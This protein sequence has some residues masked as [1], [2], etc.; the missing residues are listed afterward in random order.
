[1]QPVNIQGYYLSDND[2]HPLRWRFP[3]REIPPG[4][5]LLVF[6]SGKN[7]FGDQLHTNF[8]ISASGEPLILSDPDG[9][10]LDYIPAVP[11]PRDVSY[12]RYPDGGSHF[13]FFDLPTPGSTNI[14]PFETAI[15]FSQ[16][17]GFYADTLALEMEVEGNFQIF[18]TLNG[19]L[20]TTSDSLYIGPLVLLPS[21]DIE[22][23]PIIYIPTNHESSDWWY[24]WRM[25]GEDLFRSHVVRAR[26][27]E[28]GDP[29]TEIKTA[30]YFIDSG[31]DER[32]DLPVISIVS[33]EDGLFD[34]EN[35]IF[36][37][38]QGFEDNPQQGGFW[39]GGNFHN[40]G[41]EWEREAG[42]FFFENGE[43]ALEQNLGIRIH[44]S[45]SRSLP[46]KSLR[47]YA[48]EG[49]GK[50]EIEY[51]FFP[52]EGIQR[53]KRLLLRNAGQDFLK[54][55]LADPLTHLIISD[56]DVERQLYRPAVLFINGAY[57]GI[58]NI[59]ERLD[60]YYFESHF[61][62][63]EEEL[64]LIS[65]SWGIRYEVNTGTAND[66]LEMMEYI[67]VN[68]LSD[69]LHFDFV[70]NQIDLENFISYYIGKMF[71]GTRDWPGNN[72]DFWRDRSSDGKWRWI[73]FDNDDAFEDIY[74]N[75]YDYL[76]ILSG[77][78]WPNPLWT[79][80]LFRSLMEN[81]GFRQQFAETAVHQLKTTYHP[82]RTMEIAELAA[83]NIAY[84]MPHHIERWKYPDSF[85]DWNR[86]F[87]EILNFLAK[88]PCAFF[89][90]TRSFFEED[91]FE[92]VW[93]E[94]VS[95]VGE[96]KE[97]KVSVFP[98][99]TT[100]KIA[101][102]IDDSPEIEFI[103]IY[104][105]SGRLLFQKE[106]PFYGASGEISVDIG[107]GPPGIYLMEVIS[108]EGFRY[109]SRVVRFN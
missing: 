25:P 101:F 64:D 24:R 39:T 63:S 72:L 96:V 26:A 109:F 33:P 88:R 47:L 73:W 91:D 85:S 40:R 107:S 89:E 77:D 9:N 27:F 68:D 34:Y 59:R 10:T 23:N 14:R 44:G 17:S 8:S 61:G 56:L 79:T 22:N 105:S 69:P 16:S 80:Q 37:P 12:G 49:Y 58:I 62:V 65:H 5:Y 52:D 70:A 95:T 75:S 55:Y 30:T 84:E 86:H 18:Y 102:F 45:A 99:P 15:S 98:N 106:R 3:S 11:V 54:A 4:G 48:R 35:G 71:F 43:L 2:N 51:P 74:F 83:A 38:G 42:F 60:P 67:E 82:S 46:Q 50:N 19:D 6:A 103:R 92:L 94:C 87:Q 93:E 66:Y 29:R 32:F 21:A 28:G 76:T 20:P 7:R 97:R 100:G 108:K 81:Y 104:D 1:D 90:M 13:K 31:A 57:W 53:F 78:D 41:R 36:V